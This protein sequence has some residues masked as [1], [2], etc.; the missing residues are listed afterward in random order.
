MPDRR[1][2]DTPQGT[3]RLVQRRAES[4]W[5]TLVLTHGAGGGTDAPDLT[6]LAQQ[7]P[8]R[9]ITVALIEQ[10][11]RLVGRRVA[12]SPPVLDNGFRAAMRALRPQT[13]VIVG[14][15][16]AGARVACRTGRHLGAAGII[17]LA[18]P[19]HPAGRPDKSRASELLDARLP[20]MVVQGERDALGAPSEFPPAQPLVVIP[21][22]DHQF[23]VPVRGDVNQQET[24]DLVVQVT[25]TWIARRLRHG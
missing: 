24:L 23:R 20:S 6:A 5:A 14:G 17:A 15:R 25:L 19:L 10:P 11:W 3:A 21:A 9:G 1:L 16:S 22:A 12:P 4:P 18:F 7:L 13:P 2:I 8:R